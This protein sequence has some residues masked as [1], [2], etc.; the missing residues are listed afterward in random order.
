V[1]VG[2]TFYLNVSP[3]VEFAVSRKNTKATTKFN[4]PRHPLS[5]ISLAHHIYPFNSNIFVERNF[6]DFILLLNFEIYLII[7]ILNSIY[8]LS[9]ITEI[10]SIFMLCQKFS[11]V[12]HKG[13]FHCI[14][15]KTRTNNLIK[16]AYFSGNFIRYIAS[17][18]SPTRRRRRNW[19]SI[20]SY[21]SL[22][23]MSDAG[24][25]II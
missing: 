9:L 12:I 16:I 19:S 18:E 11:V 1:S 21:S 25:R 3:S 13:I 22:P 5:D 23:S 17:L 4:T 24:M 8:W 15:T 20:F 6:K 7:K 14:P 10:F 2:S